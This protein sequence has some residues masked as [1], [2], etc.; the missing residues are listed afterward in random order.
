MASEKDANGDGL[1]D[2][3]VHVATANLDPGAFQNG[4][5]ILTGNTFEGQAI[6]G[7]DEVNIV[8]AN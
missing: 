8:P 4:L 6:E 7:S 5:A 2:L 1:I 3:V